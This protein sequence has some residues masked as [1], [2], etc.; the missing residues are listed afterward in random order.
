MHTERILK[1]LAAQY[2]TRRAKSMPEADIY[3]FWQ[4]FQ[5]DKLNSILFFDGE[6]PNFQAFCRWLAAGDKDVRFV[7]DTAGEIQALYWLNNRF[8]KSVMIHFCFL[9]KAFCQR[10]EIGLYVVLGLLFCEEK[11]LSRADGDKIRQTPAA[12]EP[13][14]YVLSAL[15]GITPKPYRHALAFIRTLGFCPVCEL[16]E[17]CYF[18][19]KKRYVGGAVGILT[20]EGLI[21]GRAYQNMLKQYDTCVS[22]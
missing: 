12:E 10:E 2:A 11:A 13:K 19:D 9:R 21:R 4:R 17:A 22:S 14:S 8:G 1:R 3:E 15:I 18:A 5:E 7:T 6:M 16:P 20:R